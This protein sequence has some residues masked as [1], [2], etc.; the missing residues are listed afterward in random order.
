M[1]DMSCVVE[2]DAG[3]LSPRVEQRG[4]RLLEA[5]LGRDE[6]VQQDLVDASA[7]PQS[8]KWLGPE[9]ARLACQSSVAAEFQFSTEEGPT[10]TRAQ[11][12][13]GSDGQ[14]QELL[15]PMPLSPL[16]T[17]F[18]H[19]FQPG[20]DLASS[21]SHELF[22]YFGEWNDWPNQASTRAHTDAADQSEAY[23]VECA[24]QRSNTALQRQFLKTKKCRFFD[25]GRCYLGDKCRFAHSDDE[26]QS[27]PSLSK[28]KLCSD[29]FLRKCFKRNCKFAHGYGELR[30]TDVLYKTTMCR[31]FQRNACRAGPHCRFAHSV[32]ELRPSA[33]AMTALEE[34]TR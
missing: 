32:E 18:A 14:R 9:E 19:G 15:K 22:S 34:P 8:V 30:S 28:T 33:Q 2:D 4:L 16:D 23:V 25:V 3:I 26:L 21:E 29:F 20:W 12:F 11:L 1:A 6:S 10:Q 17:S 5:L 13:R 31:W 7:V 27:L 24:Q